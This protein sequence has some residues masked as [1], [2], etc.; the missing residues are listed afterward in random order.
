MKMKKWLIIGLVLWLLW[1]AWVYATLNIDTTINNL[2]SYMMKLVLT[3]DGTPDGT[4][5]IILDGADGSISMSGALNIQQW[6]LKDNT[7]VSADI[8][9]GAIT[10]AKIARNA[11][12]S[13][14]IASSAITTGK[15]AR[16]AVTSDMIA[17]SAITT[18][19]IARNAVTSDTI[20]SSAITTGKI[21]R[22]AVTSDTIASSAITTGKIARNAVSS[23]SIANGAITEDKLATDLKKKF[24]NLGFHLVTSCNANNLGMPNSHGLL[25]A[26]FSVTNAT[27][28]INSKKDGV[29]SGSKRNRSKCEIGILYSGGCHKTRHWSLRGWK[30]HCRSNLN[31]TVNFTNVY[32]F[33]H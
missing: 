13:D 19:K 8:K 27:A 29:Y 20:A 5:K 17:S 15:I 1:T 18:G 11:V 14:M 25:C 28:C 9:D 21:A 33:V 22:N 4:K 30:V 23:D 24:N 16:N 10:T 7:I 26:S 31:T 3:S 12:T 32:Y 6:A 2:Y